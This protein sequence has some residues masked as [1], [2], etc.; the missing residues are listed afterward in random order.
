MVGRR[1]FARV[2]TALAIVGA[3]V[4]TGVVGC[5]ATDTPIGRVFE[6][7]TP[8]DHVL[9]REATREIER[10]EGAYRTYASDASDDGRLKHFRD[11]FV[12]VRAEYVLDT[13]DGKLVTAAIQGVEKAKPK[14]ASKEPGEL[15]ELA[16]DAMLASLDPHSAYLNPEEL[17]D[18]Q[19][20]TTGKFG[21]LGIEV[22]ME[23]G[24]IKVISPI[25]GTP[26]ERAG[27]KP[28]DLISHIDGKS[29]KGMT[30]A[31]AVS[32][33]RG[34]IGTDVRLMVMRANRQPF[35]ITLT[36][37]I[38]TVQSVRWRRE[39]DIGY[40]RV[41]AFTSQVEEGIAEAIASLRAER[42]PRLRG[43]VLDLR[44][45]PGG[46][47]DQSVMLADA[48]MDGGVIVSIRGRGKGHQRTYSAEKG[49][50]A[51]GLP[52][53]VLINAGSASASEIVAAALQ[54]S[55]RATVMGAP[56]FGKGSVQTIMP[57]PRG[58]ALKLT[59]ALYYSPA[60]RAIQAQGIEPDIVIASEDKPALRREA[61]LP[62]AI[63]GALAAAR[64][65][66]T[67]KD[68]DCPETGADRD[69]HLGCAV[70]LLRAGSADD[71]LVSLGQTGSM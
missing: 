5:V 31:Q 62:G 47:L 34:R 64:G 56:S 10:F 29:I 38:I 16:L 25:E 55:G 19:V 40:I 3:T 63:V 15:V 53:V 6:A 17:K 18:T 68:A 69:R 1:G 49:D 50:L 36:R 59:T 60:G 35:E 42:E 61:D 21:G 71:F 24:L 9:S 7:F 20:S 12:R 27:I 22:S 4:V 13:D 45:N 51:H 66:K 67:I 44:N 43:L 58:G 65:H 57:L 28:G 14:T 70:G 33:M 30:L 48:F 2:L 41:A 52:L 23:D 32:E 46:L 37:A 39:D 11:A 54:D 8:D 26:A